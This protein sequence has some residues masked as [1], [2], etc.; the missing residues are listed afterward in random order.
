MLVALVALYRSHTFRLS[1]T[2]HPEGIMH[3][4][5]KVTPAPRDGLWVIPEKRVVAPPVGPPRAVPWQFGPT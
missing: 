3:R 2:H 5:F 4:E 1:P